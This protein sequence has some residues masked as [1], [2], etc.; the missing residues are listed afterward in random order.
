MSDD[1]GGTPRRRSGIVALTLT[2]GLGGTM[3]LAN[4]FPGQEMKR[5]LYPDRAA[6][7]RD[8][9]P[10]QC[11]QGGVSGYT[12]STWH[13]PYYHSDRSSAAARM[14]PG[15]GRM[16]WVTSTQTSMRGGFGAFGR[17]MRAVG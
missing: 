6:C 4:S 1:G 7:E 16:G 14:D 11:E 9:S 2:A 5:N 3:A 17:A 10:Q 8:Y 13:G 12:G 15:P